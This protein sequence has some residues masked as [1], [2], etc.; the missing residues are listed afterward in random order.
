M[1]E[2]STVSVM[3][4]LRQ[5]SNGARIYGVPC[6]TGTCGH[7]VNNAAFPSNC[8]S[9]WSPPHSY[10]STAI[11]VGL[12]FKKHKGMA[13]PGRGH[14][15]LFNLLVREAVNHHSCS[16]PM[17]RPPPCAP[18]KYMLQ[19]E[20]KHLPASWPQWSVSKLGH[21]PTSVQSALLSWTTHDNTPSLTYHHARNLAP[22]HEGPRTK[23][24]S[25]A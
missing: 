4:L 2:K 16:P 14:P 12:A 17:Q 25:N 20:V 7:F 15:Y 18:Q 23:W 5:F 13:W 24:K 21:H 22:L 19:H 11:S 8:T 10:T 1:M 6:S 9:S 3:S